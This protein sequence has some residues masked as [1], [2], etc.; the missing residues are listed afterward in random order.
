MHLVVFCV[1]E[2]DLYQSGEVGCGTSITL[3]TG[4]DDR[5]GQTKHDVVGVTVRD[6]CACIIL[7]SII[8]HTCVVP[9]AACSII[10]RETILRVN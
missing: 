6:V 3:E 5:R 8:V 10:N 1:F 2:C 9:V 4:R 7:A